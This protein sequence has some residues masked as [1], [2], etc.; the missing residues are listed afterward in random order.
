[1][2]DEIQ[3]TIMYKLNSAVAGLYRLDKLFVSFRQKDCS[4]SCDMAHGA[5]TT[6]TQYLYQVVINSIPGTYTY[7]Y[8]YTSIANNVTRLKGLCKK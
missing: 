6:S 5:L 8:H 3:R 2:E 1:M 4:F 7:R